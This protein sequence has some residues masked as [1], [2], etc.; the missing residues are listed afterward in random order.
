M[1]SWFIQKKMAGGGALIDVGVHNLDLAL[2]LMDYPDVQEVSG[3]VGSRFG[4]HGR[5][6]MSG[7]DDRQAQGAAF[8]VDDYAMAHLNFGNGRS[9]MLQCSWAS[10]IKEDDSGIELWGEKGGAR[11]DPL[12][13]YT[14]HRGALE[15]IV[16]RLYEVNAFDS[17]VRHFA[18]CMCSG[19]EPLL[20]AEQGCKTV[21]I[22]ESIYEAAERN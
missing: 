12:R 9:L 15:D 21:E 20:T 11:L 1:G 17:E 18:E 19:K 22:I 6:G 4:V 2:W 5:G 16:P 13:I 8:D 10:H 3:S 7:F 14:T